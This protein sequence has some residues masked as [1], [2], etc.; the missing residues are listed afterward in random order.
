MTGQKRFHPGIEE[1]AQEDP[2]GLA[3]HDDEGHEGTTCPTDL[4]LSKVAPVGLG[5]LSRKGAQAQIGLGLLA[6]SVAGNHMAEVTAVATISP[7]ADHCVE[8][9]CRQGG[10][11]LKSLQNERQIGVDLAWPSSRP[12]RHQPGTGQHALNGMMVDAEL[13]G[14]GVGPPLLD[15]VVAQ[16]LSLQFGRYGH[17][18]PLD[19][20]IGMAR[21]QDGVSAVSDALF[22]VV[23]EAATTSTSASL[24][25]EP[26]CV[27]I[28][29][30]ARY[31]RL[32]AA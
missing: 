4:H 26:W 29:C 6:R 14:N 2:A 20:D 9:G 19:R 18:H 31:R 17:R 27:T 13:V 12:M 11:C 1:E 32:R 5:L 24:A 25:S 22:G 21:R 16:D 15:M 30:R 3:Q 7:L 10:E 28:L 23:T 8:S